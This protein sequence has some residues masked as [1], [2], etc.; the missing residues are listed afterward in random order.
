MSGFPSL[1]MEYGVQR[2]QHRLRI[3]AMSWGEPNTELRIAKVA[4]PPN[5]CSRLVP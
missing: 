2:G 1:G 3:H 5:P 4:N